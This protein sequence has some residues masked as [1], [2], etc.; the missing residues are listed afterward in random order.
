[1]D[2]TCDLL[3]IR[4]TCN[5]FTQETKRAH[6]IQTFEAISKWPVQYRYQI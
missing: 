1:M 4:L 5:H 3:R 2:R 6:F